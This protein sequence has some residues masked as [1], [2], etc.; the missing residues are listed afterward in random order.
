MI[1][2]VWRGA[3]RAEDAEEYA[4]YVEK[5]A[6][7][8]ARALPGNR[9]TLVLRRVHGDKAEFETILLFDELESIHAFAGDDIDTAVFFPEDDRYLVERELTVRHFDVDV[10][11]PG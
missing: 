8:G 10:H 9:G 4:A 5:S 6:M 2:R 1:A 3:T 11:V 7:E